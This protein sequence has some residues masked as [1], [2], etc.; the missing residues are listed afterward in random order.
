MCAAACDGLLETVTTFMDL[1]AFTRAYAVAHGLIP[2]LEGLTEK[3]AHMDAARLAY[4]LEGVR[5]AMP[6]PDLG[7]RTPPSVSRLA[8]E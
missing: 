7:P 2:L 8:C 4:V 1:S 3:C 6:R 5:C